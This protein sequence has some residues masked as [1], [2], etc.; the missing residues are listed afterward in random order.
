M[1]GKLGG[2]LMGRDEEER[3]GTE[4]VETDNWTHFEEDFEDQNRVVASSD[5][6]RDDDTNITAIKAGPLFSASLLEP[7]KFEDSEKIGD[8]LISGRFTILNISNISREE[9]QRIIDFAFGLV[10]GLGGKIEPVSE[11]VFLLAPKTISV[12]TPKTTAS[13]N[14]QFGIGN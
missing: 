13:R 2:Y 12:E 3:M 8:S 14:S 6:F 4:V 5:R 9:A 10:Y 11:S 1:V 7:T